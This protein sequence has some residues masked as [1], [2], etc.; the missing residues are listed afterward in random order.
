MNQGNPS[1]P[2]PSAVPNCTC[3]AS[4]CPLHP[5]LHCPSE[6]LTLVQRVENLERLMANLQDRIENQLLNVLM[7][8]AAR[9]ARESETPTTSGGGC[10]QCGVYEAALREA[11]LVG[12]DAAWALWDLAEAG[13]TQPA[14]TSGPPPSERTPAG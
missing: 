3:P 13:R 5:F 1:N 8:E 10:P 12:K 9:R 14:M 4:D 7:A 11:A 2:D 6:T